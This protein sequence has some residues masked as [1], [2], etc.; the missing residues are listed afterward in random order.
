MTT[1]VK[2]VIESRKEKQATTDAHLLGWL[3]AYPASSA[4]EVATVFD[5]HPATVYRRVAWFLENGW[6]QRVSGYGG[7]ARFLLTRA[8]TAFLAQGIQ[9]DI[10]EVRTWQK[11]LAAPGRLL[12]RLMML[13]RL[14]SF[15]LDFFC[16]A[17][18][19]L[20]HQGHAVMVRWHFM[21]DW[22][23][24][25]PMTQSHAIAVQAQAVLAWTITESYQ[26]ASRTWAT[27]KRHPKT[28][29]WHTAFLL[30]ESGLYDPARIRAQ[31]H[32]LRRYQATN[33][34]YEC[35]QRVPFFPAVLV[36]V[37]NERQAEVWC[38]AARE[39]ASSTDA[40]LTGMLAIL[41][42]Q[43]NPWQ[44]SWRT[45]TTGAHI[46]LATQ[47]AASSPTLPQGVLT[48]LTN[49]QDL[50]QACEQDGVPSATKAERKK[51][52]G[53][54]LA[55]RTAIS[56]ATWVCSPR[57]RDVLTQLARTP[58]MTADELAAVLPHSNGKSLTSASAERLLR[59]LVHVHLVERNVIAYGNTGA[60]RWFLTESGLRQVAAMHEVSLLHLKR[61]AERSRFL[62]QRQGAHQAG[63]YSVIAA[64][65]QSAGARQNQRM[66]TVAWWE[67]GWLAEHTFRFHGIQRNLRPDAELK[68]VVRN[69]GQPNR[70]MRVWIEWDT[71]TMNQR[72][73]A[74]KM[75]AYADYW[76]SQTWA[77]EGLAALPRLLF[78]VP[79][80][81]QEERVRRA[82][83]DTLVRAGVRL[84]VMVTTAAHLATYTPYG[85]IWRQ[86][87][88]P[89][90]E[91]DATKRRMFW[92]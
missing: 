84:R 40:P 32:T 54:K 15:V 19:A 63:I 53:T 49:I 30:L 41:S 70:R 77:A 13:D 57:Q 21:R 35:G 14:H 87:L 12:P 68:L 25:L 74:R 37:E 3:L 4:Q 51:V 86:I 6:L 75:A 7:E 80:H 69:T 23:A 29:R 45:L 61:Q 66:I 28:T 82:C 59:D 8:G 58:H 47:F 92:E 43:A 44:W 22:R 5:L 89:S 24:H 31:L 90:A 79:E 81:C 73:L 64:F 16:Y 65:H 17:P 20:A 2:K 50:M 88:P 72:D 36:L 39:S 9:R 78:I 60:W 85:C 1:T 91:D 71:G 56:S 38:R 83:L 33:E 76:T 26:D 67:C 52:I 55:G 42:Q 27:E 62:M 11:G 34:A 48:H 46:Q 18:I 10:A